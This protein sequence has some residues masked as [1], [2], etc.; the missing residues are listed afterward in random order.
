MENFDLVD[1]PDN[2]AYA[3]CREC[4]RKIDA[5]DIL[6]SG[7]SQFCYFCNRMKIQRF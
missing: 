4:G 6:E 2:N 5:Q 7:E 3:M 1:T